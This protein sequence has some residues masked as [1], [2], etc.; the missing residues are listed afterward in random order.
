LLQELRYGAREDVQVVI[1]HTRL[2]GSE[3]AAQRS[4]QAGG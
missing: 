1:M 2:D 3:L 4:V